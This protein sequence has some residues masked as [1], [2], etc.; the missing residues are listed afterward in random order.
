M[1]ICPKTEGRRGYGDVKV[2]SNFFCHCSGLLKPYSSRDV[3]NKFKGV[4]A[5]GDDINAH[6]ED[7]SL[8]VL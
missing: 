7:K 2:N 8:F 6:L 3:T 4:V 5:L 1:E